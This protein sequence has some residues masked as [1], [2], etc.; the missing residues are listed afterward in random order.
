MTEATTKV[1]GETT[2]NTDTELTPG[3][4]G[5][6]TPGHS[7]L[8]KSTVKV[9]T[10]GLTVEFIMENGTKERFMEMEY[11]LGPM[12]NTTTANTTWTKNKESV[13]INGPTANNTK[14]A[15][16]PANNT[17]REK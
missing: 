7:Q 3:K 12:A 9:S 14:V 13:P 11:T 15:G 2:Q 5:L 6:F 17:A 16:S 10:L 1:N 8:T 4:M